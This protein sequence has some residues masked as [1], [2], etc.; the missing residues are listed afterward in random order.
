MLGN[1][2]KIYIYK[3]KKTHKVI[4]TS[5]ESGVGHSWVFVFS[6]LVVGHCP[7]SLDCARERRHFCQPGSS[8]CGPCLDPFVE[9]KRGKC[10]VRRRNHSGEYCQHQTESY[11]KY[12][13]R[14][15]S[16]LGSRIFNSSGK[17]ARPT[18]MDRERQKSEKNCLPKYHLDNITNQ[19]PNLT[20]TIL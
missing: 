6:V 12:L 4:R 10:V 19:Q 7:R 9:N 8:H 18:F 11:K 20:L 2:H 5:T 13:S 3:K 16:S 14:K 1:C 15:V 17:H